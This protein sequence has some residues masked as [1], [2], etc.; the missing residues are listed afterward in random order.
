MNAP[1]HPDFPMDKA[2]ARRLGRAAPH[3]GAGGDLAGFAR[4]LDGA[5]TAAFTAT[6]LFGAVIIFA[7]LEGLHASE[8]A[9]VW[10]LAAA[11][12]GAAAVLTLLWRRSSEQRGRLQDEIERLREDAERARRQL[13]GEAAF[14]AEFRDDPRY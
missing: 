11:M 9:P 8:A 7:L 10:A 5:A 4:R 14:F 2:L 12:A 13:R 1:Y 3:G 6:A